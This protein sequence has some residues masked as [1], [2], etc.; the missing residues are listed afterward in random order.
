MAGGPRPPSAPGLWSVIPGIVLDFEQQRAAR[1]IRHE[2]GPAPTTGA[3]GVKTPATA[4]FAR[5]ASA[6]ADRPEG[7]KVTRVSSREILCLVVI[8]TSSASRFGSTAS[9]PALQHGKRCIPCPVIQASAN[10]A[11]SIRAAGPS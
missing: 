10:T 11:L 3:H 5:C 4:R 8:K 2:I 7:Q 1:R 9:A 6:G